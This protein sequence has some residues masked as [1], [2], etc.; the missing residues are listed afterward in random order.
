[1]T[2][3]VPADLEL[4]WAVLPWPCRPKHHLASIHQPVV[5]TR[6]IYSLEKIIAGYMVYLYPYEGRPNNEFDLSIWNTSNYSE[7]QFNVLIIV[8]TSVLVGN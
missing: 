6:Q 7:F 8:T 1:M 5:P 2:G 4:T 3:I